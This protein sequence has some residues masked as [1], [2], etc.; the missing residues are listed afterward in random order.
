ML[1][2]AHRSEGSLGFVINQGAP[3]TFGNV[4][5]ELGL[6]EEVGDVPDVPV[7]TGGPVAPESG[8][9]L[10]DPRRSDWE[11]EENVLEVNDTIHISTSREL[12]DSIARQPELERHILLLGYAGWGPG[13]LD[14]EIKQGA[15]IP[16]DLDAHVVFDTPITQ[17][18]TAALAT[19]GIDPMVLV[20][21]PLALA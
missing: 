1:L 7:L 6:D 15:W 16:V 18:W 8:W 11:E 4:M 17:R 14:D 3:L 12:L 21:T 5:S 19:A 2:T 13:Q 10:F 9:V 20:N